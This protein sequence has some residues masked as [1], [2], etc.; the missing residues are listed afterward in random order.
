MRLA[1]GGLNILLGAVYTGYGVMTIID[2]NREWNRRGF[3]HFGLAWIAM[4]FTCGP[5][6]LEHGYHVAFAGRAGGPLD[7]F[8]VLV[9]LPA[10]V[11]WFLLRVEALAGG[12]G[13]RFVPGTPQGVGALPVV[14][15]AY[16][17]IYIGAAAI[18][19]RGGGDFGPKLVPNVLLLGLY[20]M[21][22]Y[23]LLRT[24][25][26]NHDSLAGWSL[27][28]LSLT[29]VFP[30]CGLMHAVSVIYAAAGRYDV[31][32]HGLTIDWLAVPAAVYF[33][34]VVRALH[35]GAF[36]DWNRGATGVRREQVEVAP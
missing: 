19:L 9:G 17:A 16:L 12:R 4:A 33:L 1:V 20:G 8:A 36:T 18:A 25:L 13:D 26:A 27:S 2:L 15:T 32:V 14:S 30:T 10:G 7:L 29:V 11:I 24:Q 23:Y 28:G 3:S 22:G 6:H 5:H 21:I 35:H 34:W 31:D